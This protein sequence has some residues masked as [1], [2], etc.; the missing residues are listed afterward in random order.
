MLLNTIYIVKLYVCRLD[1]GDF[2]Y[3]AANHMKMQIFVATYMSNLF[4]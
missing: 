4:Q 1:K 2:K 3:V